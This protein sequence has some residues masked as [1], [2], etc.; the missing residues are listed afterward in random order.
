MR[1]LQRVCEAIAEELLQDASDVQRVCLAHSSSSMHPY[2][3]QL[4]VREVRCETM[5]Q[6]L[7]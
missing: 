6:T 7:C 4:L 3:Q 1:P 2:K 5:L